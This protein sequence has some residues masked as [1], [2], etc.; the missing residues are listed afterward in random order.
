ME[1]SFFNGHLYHFLLCY[2]LLS[3]AAFAFCAFC[4]NLSLSSTNITCL[5][6]L[7]IHAW[8]HLIHLQLLM[9]YLDYSA[10]S[11]TSAAWFYIIASFAFAYFAA[12][13]SFVWCLNS[14]SIVDL[15]KCDFQCFFCRFDFLHFSSSTW[16]STSTEK[17]VHN[18]TVI[19]LGSF[20]AIFIIDSPLF[21]IR[22]CLIC[23]TDFFKLYIL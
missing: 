10:F 6:N 7:L 16:S 23:L 22:K 15:F 1:S 18:I 8:T 13:R 14:C 21:G 3:K 20:G 9:K 5:L 19:C 12:T 17:H 4:N 11:F 2:N